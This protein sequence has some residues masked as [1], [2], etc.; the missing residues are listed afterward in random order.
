MP[1]PRRLQAHLQHPHSCRDAHPQVPLSLRTRPRFPRVPLSHLVRRRW[2][3][4]LA[5]VPGRAA[6]TRSGTSGRSATG[7]LR[8]VMLRGSALARLRLCSHKISYTL[9]VC[10]DHL[11]PTLRSLSLYYALTLSSLLLLYVC[12]Y[13]DA[14]RQSLEGVLPC[15]I[16]TVI[17]RVTTLQSSLSL[18]YAPPPSWHSGPRFQAVGASNVPLESD[19]APRIVACRAVP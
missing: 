5:R 11:R 2:P 19:L 16:I 14:D 9:F 6:S 12:T 10:H 18:T 17:L 3:P 4:F 15:C 8:L 7:V 13:L 1:I